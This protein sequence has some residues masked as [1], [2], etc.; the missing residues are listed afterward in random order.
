MFGIGGLALVL[1]S[2]CVKIEGGAAEFSWSLRDE[3]GRSVECTNNDPAGDVGE[4]RLCWVS[5]VDAG[6]SIAQCRP[7]D[8]QTFPCAEGSGATGFTLTPSRTSLFIQPVCADGTPAA[9]ASYT[10]PP[11]IVREVVEGRV[12]TLSSLLVV[13]KRTACCTQVGESPC[14]LCTCKSL[15]G[16]I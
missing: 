5:L 6:S 2:G 8:L 12:V 16:S 7:P 15:A 14:T 1:V 4:I 10:V 11:P 9:P 13:I 3:Q